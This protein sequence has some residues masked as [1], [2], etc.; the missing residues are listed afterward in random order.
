MHMYT[1]SG[2]FTSMETIPLKDRIVNSLG[3]VGFLWSLLYILLLL[4]F[5]F[6]LQLYK[7]VKTILR[8]TKSKAKQKQTAEQIDLQALALE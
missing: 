2:A 1:Y 3:F 4:L 6:F 7:N 5:L 8:S